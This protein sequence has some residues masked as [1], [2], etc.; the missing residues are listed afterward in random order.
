MAA[1]CAVFAGPPRLDLPPR[2]P[3]RNSGGVVTP[4]QLPCLQSIGSSLSRYAA[5]ATRQHPTRQPISATRES[6]IRGQEKNNDQKAGRTNCTR[7]GWV[8]R[9]WRCHRK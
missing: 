8:A 4:F 3:L 9:H 7:N 2:Q 1:T 5:N 6:E